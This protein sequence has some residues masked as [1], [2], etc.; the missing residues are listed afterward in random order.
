[1]PEKLKK[2]LAAGLRLRT[3]GWLGQTGGVLRLVL[4]GTSAMEMLNFD[5]DSVSESKLH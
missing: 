4:L 2:R 3:K 1:M 5:V